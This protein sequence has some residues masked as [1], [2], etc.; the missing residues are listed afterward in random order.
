MKFK[1]ITMY[2][3]FSFIVFFCFSKLLI[4]SPKHDPNVP[5]F[6][7]VENPID[8]DIHT[9]IK[10]SYS[11]YELNL[12]S[13]L[14][15]AEAGSDWLS[16]EHQFAVGSVVLNRVSDDRFPNTIHSVIYQTNPVQYSCT[17]NG[18]INKT[19]NERA[20]NNAKYL[21]EKGSTIPKNVVWQSTIPQGKGVWDVIEGHY[22]CY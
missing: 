3:L 12:L 16:D 10:K 9:E 5:V 18:M 22:F 6:T 15:F 20:I 14:I 19:P 7:L 17:V 4:F 2:I 1:K 11:E 8:N 21:L 13:R